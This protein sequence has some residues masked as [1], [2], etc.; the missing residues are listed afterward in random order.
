M[1]PTLTDFTYQFTDAGVVLNQDA[2]VLPFIDV[3]KITG[4]DSAAFRTSTRDTEGID[5][6]IVEAEFETIRTIIIEGTIYGTP[7][8]IFDML[9]DMKGNFGPAV[10][11]QPFYFKH[12]SQGQRYVTCKSLGMKYDLAS[13]IRLATTPY[14][15]QLQAADPTIYDQ[16]LK[17]ATGGLPPSAA[18]GRGYPKSYPRSYGGITESGIIVVENEGNK[19]TPGIITIPGPVVLPKITSDTDGG[20]FLQVN[21]D[22]GIT[23]FLVIDL[24]KRTI[25]LNGTASRRNLLTGLSRWFQILP[26]VNNFRFSAQTQTGSDVLF[27]WHD[28]YR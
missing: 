23:E 27:E 26:G 5:G 21:I 13:A 22:L 11:S 7:T 10:A 1:P 14:Q 15:I 6:G 20:K 12:P 8:T 24:G 16:A 28:G 17:S 25:M 18:Q 3:E 4:L 19:P 9:D 2:A